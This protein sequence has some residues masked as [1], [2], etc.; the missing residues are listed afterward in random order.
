[1]EKSLK[2]QDSIFDV[3]DIISNKNSK[4]YFYPTIDI[5]N[6]HP[7]GNITSKFEWYIYYLVLQIL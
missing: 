2:S 4:L 6:A 1:M 7:L 3:F 5:G